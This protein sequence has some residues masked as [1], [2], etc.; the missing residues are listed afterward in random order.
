MKIRL[1]E[2]KSVVPKS[3][4]DLVPTAKQQ[5]RLYESKSLVPTAKLDLPMNGCKKT[6]NRKSEFWEAGK[7]IPA[8]FFAREFLIL[9][10]GFLFSF[11]ECEVLLVHWFETWL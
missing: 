7:G 5:I 6:E 1:Y 9:L 4:I 3:I 2:S 10:C 11:F 8:K